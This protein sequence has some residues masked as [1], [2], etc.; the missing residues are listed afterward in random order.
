[1]TGTASGTTD[2]LITANN[3]PEV[4]QRIEATLS[5][6][7]NQP[8][9]LALAM[10]SL[11]EEGSIELF[12]FSVSVTGNSNEEA[13]NLV[14]IPEVLNAE[15]D[16]QLRLN[17]DTNFVT[18]DK[19]GVATESGALIDDGLGKWDEDEFLSDYANS[20]YVDVNNLQRCRKWNWQATGFDNLIKIAGVPS[21][22]KEG[23]RIVQ[24]DTGYTDHHKVL[25]GFD[26]EHDFNFLTNMDDAN[27]PRTIGLGKQPGHGTR[28]GSLL[29]GNA[30]L[31]IEHNGNVGLLSPDGFKLVPFR[32]AETVILINRQKQLASALDRAVSQGFDIITMSMGLPPTIATAKMAKKAYDN[33]VVWCCAAGNEVKVV[34]APAVFPGTIAVAASNPLDKIWKGSSRGD[35]VDITAPG[36]DVYVPIWNEERN[37]D[38][39]YGNGTSYATPHIAAAAAYWLAKYRTE[40]NKP[41]FS[42]WKRVEA[43]RDALKRS[44]RKPA[45]F[46]RDA[47]AGILDVDTLINTPPLPA[48]DLKYAYNGWNENAFFASIQGYGELLKTYWNGLHGW[49]TGKKKSGEEAISTKLYLFLPL[50]KN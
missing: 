12:S 5:N 1:M 42:G 44:A 23:I 17:A 35:T 8:V 9:K 32:I 7:Y 18:T 41:E 21:P 27:D 16:F 26:L 22:R 14:K 10:P 30:D 31:P 49:L 3:K 37:E 34:I 2:F 29:V 4:I 38:F 20:P 13:L 39:A 33:G 36:Q 11:A 47:G 40:L 24:F 46:P 45:N 50:L 19:R 43:F 28:T 15:V 48:K 6:R 25:G